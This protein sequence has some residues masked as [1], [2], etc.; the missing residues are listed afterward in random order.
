MVLGLT[1]PQLRDEVLNA[2]APAPEQA[3]RSGKFPKLTFKMKQF[4]VHPETEE[5][6]A[7]EPDFLG[8]RLQEREAA[9]AHEDDAVN[10][11]VFE[12]VPEIEID[13]KVSYKYT[14]VLIFIHLLSKL[15][16]MNIQGGTEN[17]K[18][19]DLFTRIQARL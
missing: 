18:L 7:K 17:I 8:F 9:Q 12:G 4:G 13:T 15:V 19:V 11:S 10:H 3:V 6:Y 2:P 16:N 1:E 14:Y 5:Y